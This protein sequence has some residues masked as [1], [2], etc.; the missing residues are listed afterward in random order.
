MIAILLTVLLAPTHETGPMAI[1]REEWFACAGEQADRILANTEDGPEAVAEQAMRACDGS[2][3]LYETA[4][5]RA[6][7]MEDASR[8]SSDRVETQVYLLAARVRGSV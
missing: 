2:R 6:N 7:D 5:A 3:Q 8:Q 1:A 4:A